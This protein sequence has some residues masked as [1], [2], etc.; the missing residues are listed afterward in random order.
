MEACIYKKF[1]KKNRLVFVHSSYKDLS[2][3]A[4]WIDSDKLFPH[5]QKI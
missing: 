3:L 1:G 2:Q 4:D 5:I